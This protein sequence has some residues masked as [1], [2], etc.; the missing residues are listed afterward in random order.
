MHYGLWVGALLESGHLE[1]RQVVGGQHKCLFSGRKLWGREVCGTG[2]ALCPVASFFPSAIEPSSSTARV[3]I[4]CEMM[5]HDVDISC[6]H[7][8][9]ITLYWVLVI[10]L[11]QCP[12][13]G[14]LLQSTF[15]VAGPTQRYSVFLSSWYELN[16]S[17]SSLPLWNLRVHH[18]EHKSP[19]WTRSEFSPYLH[20]QFL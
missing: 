19:H 14:A 6:Q 17:V 4:Y 20:T 18:L 16:P 7:R 12:S 13:R 3:L 10:I 11:C 2:S 8:V 1:D 5:S 9:S 15:V